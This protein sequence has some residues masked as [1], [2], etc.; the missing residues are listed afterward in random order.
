MLA[1]KKSD[2]DGGEIIVWL[3]STNPK[4]FFLIKIT[5]KY[6]YVASEYLL[7]AKN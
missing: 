6:K 3:I 4:K 5:Y 7:I 2:Y 1:N